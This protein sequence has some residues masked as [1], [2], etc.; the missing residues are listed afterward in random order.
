M[1]SIENL[2]GSLEPVEYLARSPSR[3]E[4]LDA[5]HQDPRT[6]T[7]L[8]E[9]TDV[10][11]V[12]LSRILANFEDRGWI[13]RTN[14]GYEATSR[15]SFVATELTGLLANIQTL[16]HLDG[17]MEWLPTEEFDFELTCLRDADVSTSS[18]GDHT[19]QI[20]HVAESIPGS[21]RIV[22]TASGVS[23]DVIDALWETTVNGD[24][25]FEALLDT[26][27]LEIIRAD[28]ELRRQVREMIGSGT[29]DWLLYE[30]EK[31]PLPMLMTC[32]DTVIL[33]G[34]DEDGPPPGTLET[35]D[36][37]VRSWAE[38]YF[39]AV[40]ADARPLDADAFSP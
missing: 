7:E 37:A 39:D 27:A 17:V 9:L 18:W 19:A 13:E 6:R 4:V 36:E 32:D 20:R 10:S 40:R 2:E 23:R 8:K 33:C 16:D 31:E 30:G 15:G 11:R 29:T 26:T 5:I 22:A 25:T 38:S 35:T 1:G 12:T 34:H 3:L 28:E 21:D 14:G 24:A